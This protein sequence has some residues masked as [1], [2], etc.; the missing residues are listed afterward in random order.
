MD[1]PARFINHSCEAN[2]G[3]CDNDLGAFDFISLVPIACGEELTWVSRQTRSKRFSLLNVECQT[4]YTVQLR[5]H[6]N[7]LSVQD[8]G[9]AEFNSIS[10]ETCLCGKPKCRGKNLGFRESHQSIRNQYSPLFAKY[11]HEWHQKGGDVMR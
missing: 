4:L 11:L 6:F 2:V 9:G 7:V 3:I 8:Y 1:L 5:Q 10:I